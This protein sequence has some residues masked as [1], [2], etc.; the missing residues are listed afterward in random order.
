MSD[1]RMLQ[2]LVELHSGLDRQG[3]GNRESTLRALEMCRGLPA[4]PRIADI[5]SGA[6]AQTLDLARATRGNITAVDLF[7]DFLTT[8]R[9]KAEDEGLADRLRTIATDMHDLPFAKG[10]FDL[11]WSEGA[12]YIMGFDQGLESWRQYVRSHGWLCVTELSYT[13]SDAPKECRD[14]WE[15]SYPAMRDVAA[16]VAAAQELGWQVLGHFTLPD[17]AWTND[18]Y[19]PLGARLDTFQ[20]KHAA[21]V[22]ARRV[23]EMTTAEMRLFHEYSR[24]YGYVFYVM[25]RSD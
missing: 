21:D 5:G 3:P 6:G 20:A 22:D 11:I 24:Y 17:S 13:R 4:E 8:L 14:Y 12:I 7:E 19:G 1:E 18:Y 9:R 25:T 23:V 10:E 16:N 2:L 15:K